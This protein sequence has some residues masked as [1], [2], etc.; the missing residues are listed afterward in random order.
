MEKV[1]QLSSAVT[2]LAIDEDLLLIGSILA[3]A[4]VGLVLFWILF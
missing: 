2:K 3:L 4:A 1:P